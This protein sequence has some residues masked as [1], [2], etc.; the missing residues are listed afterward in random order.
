MDRRERIQQG[1]VLANFSFLFAYLLF[2][3]N[4]PLIGM[5]AVTAL[6]LTLLGYY[7]YRAMCSLRSSPSA[8]DSDAP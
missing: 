5:I 2:M 7:G 4:L 8:D 1:I 3:A 6:Y